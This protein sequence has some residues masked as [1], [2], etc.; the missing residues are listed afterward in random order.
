MLVGS[1]VGIAVGLDVTGARVGC[2]VGGL[3]GLGVG[4]FV[5]NSEGD[6]E[7]DGASVR[8]KHVNVPASNNTHESKIRS[9]TSATTNLILFQ[10]FCGEPLAVK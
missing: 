10:S 1:L 2:I 7:M 9:P 8:S 3:V 4:N 5:G 6:I